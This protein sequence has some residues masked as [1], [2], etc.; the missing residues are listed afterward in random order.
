MYRWVVAGGLIER[1]G[2]L[3]LV[4]NHRRDGRVDWTPPGGVIDAGEGLLVGLQREVREET[5]LDVCEWSGPAY[6]VEAEAPDMAWHLRVEVHLAGPAD[7]ALVVEDP[8]GIVDAARF[9]P[10]AEVEQRLAASPRWVVE[11]LVDWLRDRPAAPRTF[12]Y[13]VRGTPGEGLAVERRS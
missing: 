7:G 11:P 13:E 4:R 6:R 2:A 9:V 8:D 10:F 1:E 12:S 3:L 5:G